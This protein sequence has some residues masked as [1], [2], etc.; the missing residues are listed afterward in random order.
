MTS[1]TEGCLSINIHQPGPLYI[2]YR[3]GHDPLKAAAR[4]L[5]RGDPR[6]KSTLARSV[7]LEV[8]EFIY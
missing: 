6:H 3:H 4:E 2:M 1:I 7:Y 8:V 5:L